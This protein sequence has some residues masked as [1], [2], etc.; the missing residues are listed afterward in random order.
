MKLKK[1]FTGGGVISNLVIKDDLITL[2][3]NINNLN[4]QI[5]LLLN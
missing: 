5:V 1:D 4:K 2:S 3:Y